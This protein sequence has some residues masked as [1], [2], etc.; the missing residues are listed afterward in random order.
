METGRGQSGWPVEHSEEKG[1]ES[2]VVIPRFLCGS[3]CLCQLRTEGLVPM[4][5]YWTYRSHVGDMGPVSLVGH[6]RQKVVLSLLLHWLDW[7]RNWV[8]TYVSVGRSACWGLCREPFF[9]GAVGSIQICRWL[10]KG[11]Y[12]LST[13]DTYGLGPYADWAWDACDVLAAFPPT[14]CTSIRITVTPGYE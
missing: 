8:R 9:S 7:E 14:G 5:K 10:T 6:H 11:C 2:D 13:W 1:E 4:S 3:P 12:A